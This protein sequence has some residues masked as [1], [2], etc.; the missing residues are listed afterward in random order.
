[1]GINDRNQAVGMSSTSGDAATH[2]TLWNG[3]RA[4]DLGTLGGSYSS[5]SDI[6]NRGAVVGYS[7]LAGDTASR[8]TLWSGNRKIDLGT[9]GGTSSSA[10]A[11]NEAGLVVGASDLAGDAAQHATLWRGDQA[12]DLG[13]LPGHA[14]SGAHGINSHGQVVGY[15]AAPLGGRPTAT[16]WDDG[17]II[18][19][20]T[21]VGSGENGF[22]LYE[23]NDI[24][25]RGQIAA[26]G[27]NSAFETRAYLLTPTFTARS[28]TELLATATL[29]KAV[30]GTDGGAMLAGSATAAEATA[31]PE[32]GS[33]MLAGMGIM[34][35]LAWRR[36]AP[37]S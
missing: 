37:R 2:A 13:A 29:V 8:A 30:D 12:L 3:R 33:M 22:L 31:V 23:A 6:N 5:A 18:D 21:L 15:S 26:T 16:L 17:S 28:A 1:M 7:G 9:L 11:I 32:P 4:T 24:N 20:N 36:R 14:Y 35:M 25:D 19:L 27:Q 34:A 10:Q